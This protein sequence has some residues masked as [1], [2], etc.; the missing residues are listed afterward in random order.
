MNAI[1]A[2][3]K[4]KDRKPTKGTKILNPLSEPSLTSN[5]MIQSNTT[6]SYYT[7][8]VTYDL[9]KKCLLLVLFRDGILLVLCLETITKYNVRI[10]RHYNIVNDING[11][12]LLIKLLARLSIYLS[13]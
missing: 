11:N 5:W 1:G 4:S 3:V 13:V 2:K 6:K 9:E 8:I 10:S 12:R 7:L